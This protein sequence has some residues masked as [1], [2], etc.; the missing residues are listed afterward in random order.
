V[1]RHDTPSNPQELEELGTEAI[2][3]HQTGAHLPQRRVQVTEEQRSVVIAEPLVVLPKPFRAERSEKTVVIRDRRELDAARDRVALRRKRA[4]RARLLFFSVLALA[5]LAGV[6]V[7]VFGVSAWRSKSPRLFG[8]TPAEDA[9]SGAAAPGAP[10]AAHP[11]GAEA[12]PRTVSVDE[13]PVEKKPRR[14]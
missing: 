9:T 5:I 6:A 8:V 10:S 7:G 3:A 12:T 2:V 1:A 4:P 14:R 13:L 11:T